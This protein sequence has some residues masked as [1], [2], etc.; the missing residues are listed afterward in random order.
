[1]PFLMLFL[2]CV[3]IILIR[4]LWNHRIK[5]CRNCHRAISY[6]EYKAYGGFCFS[7]KCQAVKEWLQ[8]LDKEQ[9]TRKQFY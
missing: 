3:F 1:M 6:K 2:I 8:M 4:Y 5:E 7:Q 9:R